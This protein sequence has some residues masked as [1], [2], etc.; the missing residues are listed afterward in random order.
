MNPSPAA[1]G[2][3]TNPLARLFMALL[4]VSL[5]AT[6]AVVNLPTGASAAELVMFDSANCS[7]CRRWDREVGVGYPD[8]DEGQR[9]PLRRIDISQ[10]SAS[11]L[12]LARTVTATPTFVLVEAGAEVGRITGYPGADFFWGQL[13]EMMGQLPPAEPAEPVRERERSA[14]LR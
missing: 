5:A 10:A 2:R 11:G 7:W 14:S 13:A 3:L 8:S 1:A 6:L 4:S 12:R 9:A